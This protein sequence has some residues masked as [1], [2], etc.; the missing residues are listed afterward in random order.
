MGIAGL[1]LG[2]GIGVFGRK[3]G[4]TCDNLKAVEMVTA[5]ARV[6]TADAGSHTDLLWA[7]KGGGGGN[8]GVVTSFTFDVHPIPDIALFT[9]EFPWS[10]AADV[11]GAWQHWMPGH[12]ARAVVQLPAPVVGFGRRHPAAHRAGHRSPGRHRPPP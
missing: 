3:Y 6:V 9:L 5:D 10:A 2:G 1:T 7:S 8:F 4:L 12:A 11:L